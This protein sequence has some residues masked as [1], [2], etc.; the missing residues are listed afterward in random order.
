M[1]NSLCPLCLQPLDTFEIEH[2]HK[3]HKA[4]QVC[5]Y[6]KHE[7]TH[8]HVEKL[9]GNWSEESPVM[10]SHSLYHSPCHEK[11]LM[12]EFRDDKLPLVQEHLDVLNKFLLSVNEEIPL[13]L[14]CLYP[15]LRNLQ[16]AAANV[17]IAIARKRD[18]IRISEAE[19]YRAKTKEQKEA[20][21]LET[22]KVEAAKIQRVNEKTDPAL[23]AKRKAIEGLMT[24]FKMSEA[25]AIA[26][27]EA[28]QQT[29]SGKAN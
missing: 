1:T 23:R 9:I 27:I 2:N 24:A 18:K 21:K 29:H 5:K 22:R 16:Q 25:A 19:V 26:M 28:Q 8:E 10:L 11:Q 3:W 12:A 17:S 15:L 4:C 7:T 14:E 13:T 20:E 6:C